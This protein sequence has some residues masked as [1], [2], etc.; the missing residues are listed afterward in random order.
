MIKVFLSINDDIVQVLPGISMLYSLS[1]LIAMMVR[2]VSVMYLPPPC[3]MIHSC[4][5]SDTTYCLL[6]PPMAGLPALEAPVFIISMIPS[7]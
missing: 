7:F 3:A 6:L 1:G 5:S 4:A 2:M